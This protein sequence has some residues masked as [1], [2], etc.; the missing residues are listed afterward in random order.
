[1]G[2]DAIDKC[3]DVIAV[4]LRGGLT[5]HDLQDLELSY[6][7]PF[8][9]AKDPV[10]YAGFVAANVID[11]DMPLCHTED[12]QNPSPN[13]MLLDVRTV[14]EFERGS[15]PGAVNIP[16]DELR[17]RLKEIP[18]DKEVLVFCETGVRSYISQRMMVQQGYKTRNLTGGYLTY[19]ACTD[20]Q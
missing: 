5:V 7:P 15:I 3:I 18:P 14:K 10:N 4:A 13:Q 20:H 1:M 19:K 2:S 12:I 9:S 11:G 6:A 16:V 8:G 17:Q